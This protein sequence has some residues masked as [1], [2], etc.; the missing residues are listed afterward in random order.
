VGPPFSPAY[1]PDP[2]EL[3][4]HIPVYVPE[5][6]YLKYVAPSD[7]DI[8]E[9]PLDYV[10]DADDDEYKEEES[11]EDDDDEEE[12]HLAPA[13]SIGITSL[14]VDHVP[15]IEKT[16][17]FKTDKSTATPPPA[18]HTTSRIFVRTQTPIPFPS[19]NPLPPLPLPS[20][21]THTSP[22]YAEAHLGYKAARIWL[23]VASPL[24]LPASSSLLP[25]PTTRHIKDV[26]EAD[27]ISPKKRTA[28]TTTTTTPMTDA[29]LK[30][31]IAQGVANALVEIEA[32]R[33]SRNGDDSH[34]SGTCSR[35]T[36]H[37]TCECT[38]SDFR[39]CQP[40]NF[41]V[42]C[43]IKYATCTRQGNALTWLNSHDKTVTYE[44]AYAMTWKTL[45]R[46]MIDRYCP[47]ESDEIKKYIGG[48][49]D[50]IYGSVMAS[51]PKTMQDAIEFA[52]K[53]MDQKNRTLV[54]HQAKNK[55]KFEDTSRNNQ[56]QQKPFKRHNVARAYTAGPGEKKPYRGS[57]PL[58]PKCTYHYD[59]QCAPKCTNCKRTGHSA[60]DWRSQLAAANNN[61]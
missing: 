7:D 27:K 52:T 22:I 55:M 41:K 11:S 14:A 13:D 17:S 35:R 31:L 20:P 32:N 25:L 43:Q 46:M 8:L 44:V 60:Q 59:G 29:Q 12:E 28:I 33:T 58:C 51:K 49:L 37:P 24:P 34:D 48:L 36:E 45:K 57:K 6:V 38:Y 4:H 21:P 10:V 19:E 50:M 5:P 3:E 47:R 30:A 2:M 16:V 53:L 26:I 39:K 61:K 42:A 40:I 1:V 23:R 56:N 18:Y 54:E 9:D 15:S